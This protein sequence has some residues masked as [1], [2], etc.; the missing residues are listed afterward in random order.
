LKWIPVLYPNPKAWFGRLQDDG[1]RVVLWMT[2]MVDSY[3]KDTRIK[4]S[5]DW[6]KM[7]AVEKGYLTGVGEQIKWWKGK[8]RFY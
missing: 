1:Y 8:G 7:A 2:T 6:F 5:E 4:E 3:S